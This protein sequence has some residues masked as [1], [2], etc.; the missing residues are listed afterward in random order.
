MTGGIGSLF[1]IAKSALA[2]SQLALT[3][4]GHN[5]ANVNTAGYSRQ[6]VVLS[7][8]PPVNG[9]PGMVGTGVY[10][11]SIRRS[12]D[13]FIELQVTLSRQNIGRLS[14]AK[15][16]LLRLQTIFGDGVNHGVAGGLAEFFRAIQD[17]S[18]NP[19]ELAARSV[20]LA[21]AAQ[22]ASS[23]NQ[24]ASDL[25]EARQSI[26]FQ[27]KQTMVEINGLARRIAE[28][29]GKIVMAELTGQNANDLRDQRQQTINELAEKIDLTTLEH[30]TGAVSVFVAR[31][32]VLVEGEVVR[33]LTA[34]EE[35]GT[36]GS[37]SIGY[38]MGGTRA[39]SINGLISNGRLRSLLDVRDVTIVDVQRTFDRIAATLANAVNQIH[40]RGFGLDGT[41]GLDVFSNPAVSAEADVFNQGTASVQSGEVTAHSLLTFHD[42]EIRFISPTAYSIIDRTTGSSVRGNYLG[43]AIAAPS[44]DEPL[45]IVTGTNDTLTVT[46]DGVA[47]GTITL[48][49]AASPGRFYT[50]G[51]ELAMEIQARINA[52]ATL[53]AAGKTV[54]VVYDTTTNRLVLTSNTTDPSSSVDVTGG[55]ARSSLGLV[56]G[57]STASSGTLTVPQTLNFDGISVTVTGTPAGGDRLS[58]NSYEGTAR[59]ITAVLTN[60]SSVAASSLRNGVPGNNVNMLELAGLQTLPF[61]HLGPA[62]LQEA[63]RRLASDFGVVVHTT[64]RD[65]EAQ[66]ILRDQ[67]D[68]MRSQVSGVSLDEELVALIKFQRAFE[69]ASRLIRVSDEMF[70]TILSLK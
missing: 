63:Y 41:T 56:S 30:A 21:K 35:P 31:G 11:A 48:S 53:Q 70:Q 13:H 29:N 39:L 59:R 43:T 2:T 33:E 19:G 25:V 49:G 17:V 67:I 5:A 9:R 47:S 46:V 42:Y 18:T 58:V 23:L 50:S 52:D 55:T 62:T 22:L 12:V 20:F 8:R 16:E 4:T 15:D 7:E 66:E 3:V 54:S 26:N 51:T 65:H 6:T 36:E 28:L 1:E 61:E 32:Q 40:R 69:A 10:A 24:A 27:I 64:D 68:A 37:V 45:S 14:V 38:S 34:M 57:L 60:P 44:R